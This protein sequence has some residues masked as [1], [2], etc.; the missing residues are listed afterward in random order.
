MNVFAI[1]VLII[2]LFLSMIPGLLALFYTVAVVLPGDEGVDINNVTIS[3]LH[4]IAP[5]SI[6]LAQWRRPM[7]S[8]RQDCRD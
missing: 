1:C 5:S 4:N 3:V 2:T 6:A 7:D 8:V